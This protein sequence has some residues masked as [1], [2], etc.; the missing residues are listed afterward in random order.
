MEEPEDYKSCLPAVVRILL[1]VFSFVYN[2]FISMEVFSGFSGMCG[3]EWWVGPVPARMA[4][5][6]WEKLWDCWPLLPRSQLSEESRLDGMVPI[7]AGSVLSKPTGG[8]AWARF[9]IK[10]AW[11]D[12]F[13]F[14]LLGGLLR[15]STCLW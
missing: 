5:L 3:L 1:L 8:G 10:E 7:A 9:I 4:L 13:S 11:E 2:C 15:K 6:G 14:K 12:I